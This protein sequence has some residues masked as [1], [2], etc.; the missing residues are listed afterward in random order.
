MTLSAQRRAER[1]GAPILPNDGF[2]NGFAG[3]AIPHHGGFTLIRNPNSRDIARIE[4][5]V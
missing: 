4:I 5:G 2:V 1:C 3:M